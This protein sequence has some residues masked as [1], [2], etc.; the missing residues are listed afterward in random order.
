MTIDLPIAERRLKNTARLMQQGMW[1]LFLIAA[2][3]MLVV[4]HN[5]GVRIGSMWMLGCAVL[6]IMVWFGLRDVLKTLVR[7]NAED[8][9][10][11]EVK[12]FLQRQDLA[13]VER[14][15]PVQEAAAQEPV[16][17]SDGFMPTGAADFVELRSTALNQPQPDLVVFDAFPA[18]EPADFQMHFHAVLQPVLPN[19]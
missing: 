1:L 18:R 15:V 13:P 4:R 17:R 5:S 19:C 6:A 8:R 3:L 12:T 9:I 14:N 16:R 11:K 7:R 2:G 10:V